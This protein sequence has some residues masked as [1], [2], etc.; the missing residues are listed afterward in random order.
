M[1]QPYVAYLTISHSMQS[2]TLRENSSL[3][4]NAHPGGFGDNIVGPISGSVVGGQHGTVN[5]H[6]TPKGKP[7]S[8]TRLILPS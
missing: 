4:A 7:F 3:G 2:I 8:L 6:T 5:V 1:E